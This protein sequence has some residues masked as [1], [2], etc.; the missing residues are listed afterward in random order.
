MSRK[1]NWSKVATL[2]AEIERQVLTLK[3]GDERFGVSVWKLYEYNRRKKLH[4]KSRRPIK[5]SR[6]PGQDKGRR[7]VGRSIRRG[8]G[9][10]TSD[11]KD[12]TAIENGDPPERRGG[13]KIELPVEV[14]ELIANHKKEDPLHGFRRIEQWLESKCFI[15]VPR[16]RIREVFREKGLLEEG[17]G[18]YDRVEGEEKGTRR[19][20]ALCPRRRWRTDHTKVYIEG[21]SVFS[22]VMIED[23][24]SRFC[25]GASL[26]SAP[27]ISGSG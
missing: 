5:P 13:K 22:L 19:F 24:Y 14:M 16:K 17:D 3:E 11:A 9:A 25:E 26:E 8:D 18:V 6:R 23:D 1:L 20:E 21:L 12:V 4:G 2:V 27:V 10:G 7:A 15:V